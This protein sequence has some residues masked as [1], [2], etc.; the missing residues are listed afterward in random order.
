MMKFTTK[1]IF[2]ICGGL[3]TL[4]ALFF[5]LGKIANYSQELDFSRF[6][7]KDWRIGFFL[8]LFYAGLNFFLAGAWFWILRFLCGEMSFPWS[9]KIYGLS[10]IGKYIP[11]NIF[12]FAGRQ[13]LGMADG[14]SGRSL[15]R[16]TVW[17][18][19]LLCSLSV[20]FCLLI[21]PLWVDDIS[22]II[23]VLAFS[24]SAYLVILVCKFQFGSE[25]SKAAMLHIFFF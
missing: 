21:C 24:V 9:L 18:I 25:I 16:S 6:V 14:I 23:S 22:N 13:A 5:V 1:R 11:G 17:E 19:V 4:A 2:S 8:S 20:L 7:A 3:I 12:Q 15:A 10:Q